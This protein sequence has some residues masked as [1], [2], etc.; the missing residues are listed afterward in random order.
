MHKIASNKAVETID[1][2]P[3]TLD[4]SQDIDSLLSMSHYDVR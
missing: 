3:V 4:K 1:D 2:S